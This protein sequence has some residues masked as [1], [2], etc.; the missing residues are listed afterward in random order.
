MVSKWIAENITAGWVLAFVLIG[1]ASYLWVTQGNIPDNLTNLL[2]I[3]V[4]FY[5]GETTGRVQTE[6]KALRRG[7]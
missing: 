6:N 5:F 2:S 1:V 4:A 3:I 7:D